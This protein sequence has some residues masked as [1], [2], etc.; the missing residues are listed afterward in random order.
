M[1][2][3]YMGPASTARPATTTQIWGPRFDMQIAPSQSTL[4]P[5]ESGNRMPT[6]GDL[7]TLHADQIL[8]FQALLAVSIR[9]RNRGRRAASIKRRTLVGATLETGPVG[10]SN[11]VRGSTRER[12]LET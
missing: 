5:L 2:I 11:P 7:S 4:G 1:A 8:V 3:L 6:M 9:F 12:V 10:D